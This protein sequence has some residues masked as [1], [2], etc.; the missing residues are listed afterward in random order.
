MKKDTATAAETSQDEAKK[1]ERYKVT[2][3]SFESRETAVKEVVKCAKSG[4]RGNI[5]IEKAAYEIEIAGNHKTKTAAEAEKK[6]MIKAGL[7]GEKITV[8]AAEVNGR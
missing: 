7:D 8:K 2:Y 1:V 6:A 4:F 3:G 5:A